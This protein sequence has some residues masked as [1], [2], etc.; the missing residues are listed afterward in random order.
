[1]SMPVGHVRHARAAVDAVAERRAAAGLLLG[2]GLLAAPCRAARRASGRS[3]TISESGSS[4]IG[5][6]AARTGT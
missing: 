6:E 3:E 5:L 4:R 1:M 2:D